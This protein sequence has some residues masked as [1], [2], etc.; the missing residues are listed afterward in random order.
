MPTVTIVICVGLTVIGCELTKLGSSMERLPTTCVTVS[1]KVGMRGLRQTDLHAGIAKIVSG[2]LE[3]KRV[4][5]QRVEMR[6]LDG[7]TDD[8]IIKNNVR[9]PVT[10]SRAS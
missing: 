10:H 8:E 3:Q 2:R 1:P 4:G 7:L 9:Q 5:M 6:E